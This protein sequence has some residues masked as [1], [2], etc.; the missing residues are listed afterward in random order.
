MRNREFDQSLHID[1]ESL[2]KYSNTRLG[3]ELYGLPRSTVIALKHGMTSGLV[4]I[5]DISAALDMGVRTL[6]RRLALYDRTFSEM[7]DLARFSLAVE[8]LLNTKDRMESISTS[9]GFTD[10]TSFTNN[11]RRQS[12]LPPTQFRKKYCSIR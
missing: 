1:I 6:Q 9:L 10:R 11:F 5:K 2:Q 12:G 7:R 3:R 4:E 8:L